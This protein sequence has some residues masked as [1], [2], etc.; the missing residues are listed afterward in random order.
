LTGPEP[1]DGWA[2]VRWRDV[3]YVLRVPDA[4][5]DYIQRLIVSRQAPYE[6]ELLEA[7]AEHLSP[8]DLILD[9]G[10]N[11]GNHTLFLAYTCGAIVEAF[12]PDRHLAS[13]IEESAV[14]N[15]IGERVKV[16]HA[17]VGASPGVAKLVVDDPTN[18]GGQ[19]TVA[20]ELQDGGETVEVVTL[21][22]FSFADPVRAIKIDVEGA[23][24]DVL[25]GARDLL[26]KY[27]PL[28]FI[29]CLTDLE[30]ECVASILEEHGYI[31]VGVWNASPTHCFAHWG[32]FPHSATLQRQLRSS[33]LARY[34]DREQIRQSRRLLDSANSRYR[35][36]FK[37]M[38]RSKERSSDEYPLEVLHSATRAAYAELEELMGEVQRARSDLARHLHTPNDQEFWKTEALRRQLSSATE[39]LGECHRDLLVE[40]ARAEVLHSRYLEWL[41][42]R[43]N[44]LEQLEITKR[45]LDRATEK[46]QESETLIERTNADSKA[47]KSSL[48]ESIARVSKMQR[49]LD[50]FEDKFET[51]SRR[52][53]LLRRD[54]RL[55]REHLS[56]REEAIAQLEA[57]RSRT[58]SEIDELRSQ[59]DRYRQTLI[60]LRESSTYRLGKAL[61]D[62]SRSPKELSRL[63]PVLR[64][65]QRAARER[66]R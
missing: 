21:D 13:A 31:W 17:A 3:E 57:S 30:F 43:A 62:A 54:L 64:T 20:S 12:E 45:D 55:V 56:S 29:E 32:E 6:Q 48:D 19:R 40:R 53:D 2:T 4:E 59:R 25:R 15:E 34:S 36:V 16:H 7:I 8:G 5:I 39:D 26:A 60:G 65:A 51:A 41:D 58:L 38:D 44:L 33:A 27:R 10:A 47:L 9:V 49:V 42:E 28:L 1:P 35:D 37:H 50:T 14:A 66:K 18:L 63:L 46:C 11:V 52:G 24:A 61:R 22:A 23:E